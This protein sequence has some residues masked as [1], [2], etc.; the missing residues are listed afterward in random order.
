MTIWNKYH[1]NRLCKED[2][3][4]FFVIIPN[5]YLPSIP[6]ACQ[7]CNRLFRTDEDVTAYQ[8]YECC[9]LCAIRWAHPQRELWKSGWRPNKTDV[10]NVL[11]EQTVL[12]IQQIKV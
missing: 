6:L 5:E 12:S 8:Q 1:R 3:R 4:G 11:K 10:Q 2:S 9:N 7:V